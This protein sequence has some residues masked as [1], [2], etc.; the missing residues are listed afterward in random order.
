MCGADPFAETIRLS[1]SLRGGRG[2]SAAFPLHL[3]IPGWCAAASFKVNGAALKTNANALG[4]QVIL[5]SWK[6]GDTVDITLPM[7]VKVEAAETIS[8]GGLGNTHNSNRNNWVVGG[9]PFATVSMGPLLF[10]LPLEKE[11]SDW[12][13]AIELAQKPR[14]T[15]RAMP[16]RWDWPLDAPLTLTASAKKIVWD[17]VWAMPSAAELRSSAADA[18]QTI[19]LVPYGCSKRF[20]ISM[21]PHV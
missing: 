4:Y 10:A 2:A 9:L 14:L 12:Q 18:A 21:F 5:R 17:D 15:R 3:R 11:G 20:H 16:R 19:E 7:E 13:F 6:T 1:V 8:T